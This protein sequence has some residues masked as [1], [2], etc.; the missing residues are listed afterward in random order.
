MCLLGLVNSLANFYG[1]AI[2]SVAV[3]CENICDLDLVHICSTT[4]IVCSV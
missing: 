3:M 1:R 4:G 2:L